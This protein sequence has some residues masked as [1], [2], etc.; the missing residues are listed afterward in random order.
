MPSF[1]QLDD[2]T[3]AATL[4]Y[5]VFDLAH[6]PASV[7]PFTAGDFK[8]ERATSMSGAEVRAHRATVLQALG[9]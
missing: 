2:E 1:V 3:L 6:A 9:L 8:A 7:T 4:N 5:V